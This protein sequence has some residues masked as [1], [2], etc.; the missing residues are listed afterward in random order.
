MWLCTHTFLMNTFLIVQTLPVPLDTKKNCACNMNALALH[1][2]FTR[3]SSRRPP[4]PTKLGFRAH[5]LRRSRR[6]YIKSRRTQDIDA[7][8]LPS[9]RPLLSGLRP[10]SFL[11]CQQCCHAGCPLTHLS[12][13]TKCAV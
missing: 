6:N 4:I 11:S 3:P 1:S 13:R 7:S 9:L 5:R 8:P 12:G 2:P 10:S